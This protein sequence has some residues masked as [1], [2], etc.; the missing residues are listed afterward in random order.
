[1]SEGNVYGSFYTAQL[2]ATVIWWWQV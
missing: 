1:M 2:G